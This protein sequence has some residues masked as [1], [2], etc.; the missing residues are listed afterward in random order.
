MARSKPRL[1]REPR[2]E[3]AYELRATGAT[4]RE[5]AA[6]L[7]TTHQTL[8]RWR[9]RFHAVRERLEEDAEK[10]CLAHLGE[11][12]TSAV[13]AHMQHVV[14]GVQT[15]SAALIS[16]VLNQ[17]FSV[18]SESQQ[19]QQSEANVESARAL[20]EAIEQGSRERDG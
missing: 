8:L 16:K 10:A 12:A 13:R 4:W 9:R 19:A 15:P 18:L 7:G 17:R 3:R 20:G 11:L 6:A 14:D 2:L 1:P 5:V